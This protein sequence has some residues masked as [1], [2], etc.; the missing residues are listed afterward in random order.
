[1]DVLFGKSAYPSKAFPTVFDKSIIKLKIIKHKKK[2]G[3]KKNS[4][5]HGNLPSHPRVIKGLIKFFG[6]GEGD[7][8]PPAY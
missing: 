2:K 4:T 6:H 8:P 5:N 7:T 3:E 1:M